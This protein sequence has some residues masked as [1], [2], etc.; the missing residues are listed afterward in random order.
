[1]LEQVGA[2]AHRLG[3]HEQ[4]RVG[5][6]SDGGRRVAPDLGVELLGGIA[7]TL[8]GELVVALHLGVRQ[9]VAGPLPRPSSGRRPC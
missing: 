2:G 3:D 7:L 9:G 4:V 1:M 5:V 8:Q 6:E